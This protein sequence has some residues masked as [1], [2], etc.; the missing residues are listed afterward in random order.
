MS[1]SNY[2]EL[3]KIT[4]K[5]QKELDRI[6]DDYAGKIFI[7]FGDPLSPAIVEKSYKGL[8]VALG[9]SDVIARNNSTILAR[10]DSFVVAWGNS[11]VHRLGNSPVVTCGCF[12]GCDDPWL[13]GDHHA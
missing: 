3:L 5:S 11:S 4:V 10:A 12:V 6:P 13:G 8:V 2:A 9:F 7:G 1:T